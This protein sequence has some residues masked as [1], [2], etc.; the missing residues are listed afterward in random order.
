MQF[1]RVAQATDFIYCYT[2]LESNKR[3]DMSFS[4]SSAPRS[5]NSNTSRPDSL[6]SMLSLLQ[7]KILYEPAN[8]ELT[9]FFP[10]DPYRLPKSNVFI[11]GVYR[12]W[13][14]VAIDDD[15]EDEDEDEDSDEEPEGLKGYKD[16]NSSEGDVVGRTAYLDIPRDCTGKKKNEDDEGLGESLGA[17]SI[18]PAR[19]SISVGMRR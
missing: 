9:T 11:Q 8:V 6:S 3:T 7:A 18:S 15:E 10:F 1:A 2:I 5:T 13:S 17:M 19:M 12:E 16:G 4:S 14:S